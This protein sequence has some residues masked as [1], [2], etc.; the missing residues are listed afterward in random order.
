MTNNWLAMQCLKPSMAKAEMISL[1]VAIG[2]SIAA[3]SACEASSA[4]CGAGSIAKAEM[5]SL[6]TTTE[7]V[8]V[9]LGPQHY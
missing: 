5:G 6:A 1:H 2:F 9:V 4:S 7:T 8:S 3:G